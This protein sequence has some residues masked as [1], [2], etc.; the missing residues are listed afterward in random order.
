MSLD[1]REQQRERTETSASIRVAWQ[2]SVGRDKFAIVHSFDVSP[3]GIRM[4][5]PEPVEPRAVL[6]LQSRQLHLHGSGSVRYCKR[7]LGHY[8]VGLEFVAGLEWKPPE[9]AKV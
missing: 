2:D 7:A 9:A 8:V 3:H 1:T 5:L 6:T 4:E